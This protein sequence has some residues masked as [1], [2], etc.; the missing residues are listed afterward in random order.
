M[1]PIGP[2]NAQALRDASAEQLGRWK[3]NLERALS[4][5]CPPEELAES[6]DSDAAWVA[7]LLAAIETELSRRATFDETSMSA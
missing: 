6:W 3:D 5:G 4:L 7:A 2:Y 1:E